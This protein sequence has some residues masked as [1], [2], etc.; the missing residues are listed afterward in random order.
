MKN[1]EFIVYLC[2]RYIEVKDDNLL[3]LNFLVDYYKC[4]KE[5][6]KED[7][8]IYYFLEKL[9][10]N[11]NISFD[12]IRR[13][14]KNDVNSYY[15][16]YIV[17]DRIDVKK[18]NSFGVYEGDINL[19]GCDLRGDLTFLKFFNIR[20]VRGDLDISNNYINSLKGC[21]RII[22]GNFNCSSNELVNL[23]GGPKF[24]LFD[25]DCG[26]NYLKSLKGCIKKVFDDFICKHNYKL[27]SLVG[28]PRI[29]FG[30]FDCSFCY[31]KKID[32][33]KKVYGS[34]KFE[35]NFFEYKDIKDI[36]LCI[37]R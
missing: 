32:Y 13:I 6:K 37:K 20:R 5:M 17:K 22:D 35:N 9:G 3:F 1:Y 26:N 10:N 27:E 28:G 29:I 30:D 15:N 21:P 18:V 19:S 16:L 25:Y 12:K 2:R 7:I 14:Y 24:V 31:L 23:I 33:I 11:Y 4:N 8:L 36:E 34:I